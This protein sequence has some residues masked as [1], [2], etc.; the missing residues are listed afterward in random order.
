VLVVLVAVA[1]VQAGVGPTA[2]TANTGG[3]GGGHGSNWDGNIGTDGG[4]GIVIIRYSDGF[5]LA[6]ATTGSPT[7]T[8]AGG[9]HIY[10]YTG[11]GTI[12]F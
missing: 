2:G 5:T 1:L 10:T 3:G 12:T 6:A 9:Y 7:Q 8:T 11:S 4:S